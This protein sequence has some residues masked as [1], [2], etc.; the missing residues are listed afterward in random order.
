MKVL[1]TGGTGYI[2]SHCALALLQRGDEVHVIDNLCNSSVKALERV[3]RLG[4]G[5]VPFY[6]TDLRD[7]EAVAKVLAEGFDAVIHFAGLKAVGE[8]V[9]IPLEYYGNNLEGTL[10]LLRGM[11]EA[12]C[13]TIVFS[14]SA[15]VYGDR[16]PVPYVEDYEP[17]DATNPYGRTKVMLERILVDLAAAEPEWR[18]GILRYFN[19]VGAHPSGE[20]GEDPQGIP[21]N[22]TPY[23][24]QVAVGRRER[25]TVF[26]D[27]YPT[28][29][30]TCLRDYIHVMDLVDGHT[31]A[32]DYLASHDPGSRA[33]NLGTGK[34]T[35]VLEVVK[36][37]E[38][39]CGR[40]IPYVIG[41]RRPGDLPATYAD[42][43]RAREE[44]GWVAKRDINDMCADLWRWQSKNPQGFNG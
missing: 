12:G 44:L 11:R 21:N 40:E 2:G 41:P 1:V 26:G 43:T 7:E 9:E 25:L 3:E 10:A 32:L 29:D 18:V 8:S 33:W 24:A 39:A 36:A 13:R 22:L 30:G 34:G 23:I 42:P 17:L 31:A 14:S 20:I 15:T 28:P 35:S 19:P 37:F 27:D 5:R 4:G 6:E 38:K 16:A